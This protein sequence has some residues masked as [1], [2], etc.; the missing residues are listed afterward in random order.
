MLAYIPYMDPMGSP[1]PSWAL[2]V[3]QDEELAELVRLGWR[4]AQALD[5]QALSHEPRRH[6]LGPG[7]PGGPGPTP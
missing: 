2:L 7:G 3:R 4:E 1:S 6:S 5:G